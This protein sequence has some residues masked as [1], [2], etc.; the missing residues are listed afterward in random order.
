MVWI[1]YLRVLMLPGFKVVADSYSNQPAGEI[2]T[3]D[4][5]I[6]AEGTTRT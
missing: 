6:D 3:H 2:D 1:E 4:D 5:V